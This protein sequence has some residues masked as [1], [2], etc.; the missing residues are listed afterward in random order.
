MGTPLTSDE[1]I[2]Q[3]GRQVIT[4]ELTCLQAMVEGLGQSFVD[5]VRAI[6]NC[7]G[8]VVIT[9]I[10]KSAIIAQKIVAT[11]NSTGTPSIYMHAADAVHGDLGIIL[12]DDIV[13]A[14]SKSG[15][16]SEILLLQP[17]LRQRGNKVIGMTSQAESTLGKCA[18][19]VLPL[20]VEAEAD[21]LNLAPTTSTTAQ[22]AV[23]D[24]L[25][26]ALLRQ[27]GFTD[28]DF[29][30]SHPG[31]NLGK[32]LYYTVADVTRSALRPEVHPAAGI[33]EVIMTISEGRVGATAVI[34]AGRLV[35]IITDGDLRRMLEQQTDLSKLT[36]ADIMSPRPKSIPDTTLAMHAQ[37]LLREYKITQ[38]IITR[39]DCYAGIIHIHDLMREG[40]Q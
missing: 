2:L 32:K 23:G 17:I 20:P 38:L 37:S 6:M 14:L 5:T 28:Q 7:K 12:P 40:M 35:G 39:Q 29:A 24:A 26:V 22:L 18:D 34:D 13:I 27:R 16:T 3:N 30:R 21:P 9:G 1:Q 36:A 33:R 4:D 19:I 10:G 8:R 25:A 15:E 11:F 31:G